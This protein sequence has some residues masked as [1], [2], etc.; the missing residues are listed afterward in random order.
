MNYSKVVLFLFSIICLIEVSSKTI[1]INPPTLLFFLIYICLLI[2]FYL[3]LNNKV[4]MNSNFKQILYTY[5]FYSLFI[6]IYGLI[7]SDSYWDYK[8][9]FTSYIPGV[10]ISFAIFIGLTY[11]K[12]INLFRSIINRIFPI[13]II[14]G[15]IFY[16]FFDKTNF[17]YGASRLASPIFIFIL[18]FPFLKKNHQL[19]VLF[20]SV[21]S[22]FI[23]PTWRT[24]ALRIFACFSFVIFYYVFSL[25]RFLINFISIIV[26]IL[27]FIFLYTGMSGKFDI[28][29][30]LSTDNQGIATGNTRTFLYIE[31]FDS[32]QYKN[33]NTLIGGGANSGYQTNVFFDSNVSNLAER[34]RYRSEVRFLNTL[35]QS[36]LIGV[37]L[38]MLIFIVPAFLAINKSNNNFS[39]LLGIYLYLSWIIYFL[40]MPLS[41]NLVY[42]IH[43][44]IIGLCLNNS[45]RNSNNEEIKLLFNK[46]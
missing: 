18:A 34:E 10:I 19:L 26:L 43:Y 35:N 31:V 4:D 28:F 22:I 27:P 9:I 38:D 6:I 41:L 7:L 39:K 3:G 37:I 15:F 46:L 30:Y 33:V 42:F 40:E 13:A 29:S 25:K 12:N 32:L 45:F 36:G 44:L 1:P 17:T 20:V 21:F 14:L 24:N 5:W 8:N 2:L 11:E 23:D 16:T